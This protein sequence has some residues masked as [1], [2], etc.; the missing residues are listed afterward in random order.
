MIRLLRD[1]PADVKDLSTLF[2]ILGA[3]AIAC[4]GVV[5]LFGLPGAAIL[6]ATLLVLNPFI[7]AS[8]WSHLTADV[9]WL[10]S[11]MLSVLWPIGILPGYWI[12]FKRKAVKAFRTKSKLL[13]LGIVVAVWN[14]I[15]SAALLFTQ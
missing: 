7:S 8:I 14:L 2:V 6:G 1:A 13:M 10:L 11:L 4:F 15:V 3:F 5:P 12:A 9:Y